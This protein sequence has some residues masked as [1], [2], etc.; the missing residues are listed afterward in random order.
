M[1]KSILIIMV[2]VLIGFTSCSKEEE[3][4]PQPTPSFKSTTQISFV[5]KLSSRGFILINSSLKSL[6]IVYSVQSGDEIRLI[7]NG[8]DIYHPTTYFSTGIILTEAYMEQDYT[9]GAILDYKGDTIMHYNGYG[10]C[11][12]FYIAP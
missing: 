12:L 5:G 6:N 1:K 3:V 7:D 9:Y 4:K 2:G 10:D 11:N 8:N